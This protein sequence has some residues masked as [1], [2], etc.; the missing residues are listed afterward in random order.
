VGEKLNGKAWPESR[1]SL[2]WSVLLP[3]LLLTLGVLGCARVKIRVSVT[4]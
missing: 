3:L 4:S 2:L 1:L